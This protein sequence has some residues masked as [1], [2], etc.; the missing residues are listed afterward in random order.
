MLEPET[1]TPPSIDPN[2]FDTIEALVYRWSPLGFWGTTLTIFLIS[3]GSLALIC[4]ITGRPYM[5][6]VMAQQD[7]LALAPEQQARMAHRLAFVWG[8]TRYI[9]ETVVWVGF[10]LSLIL[11][12]A[13]ALPERGRIMWHHIKDD[14]ERA[15]P[16]SAKADINALSHG[17]PKRWQR[18][19]TI[20][21]I[22]GLVFGLVFNIFIMLGNGGNLAIYLNSIGLW[23]ILFSPFLYALGIRGGIEV[24]RESKEIKTL[25]RSHLTVDLFHLDRLRAFGQIGLHGALSWMVM[26]AILLL[27]VADTSQVW[28]A[29]GAFIL[30][31]IGAAM[32]FTSAVHPVHVLIRDAKH[33]E[34]DRIHDEM[35]RARDHALSGDAEASSALAGLTDYEQW[36]EKQ[37]EW[38]ISPGVTLRFATYILIPIIPIVGSYVFERL[39][40]FMI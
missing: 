21:L 29:I 35:A 32:I 8:E 17:A 22:G 25:I 11:T 24:A 2:R 36:V 1:Q 14:L 38:P 13:M 40:D 16:D 37:Y 30:S 34:L 12:A 23:F 26:A 3:F 9:L 39:A 20:G 19:Y 27:F 28:V 18:G 15:L 10:V 33:A 6:D 4:E 7:Y 5:F 31:G